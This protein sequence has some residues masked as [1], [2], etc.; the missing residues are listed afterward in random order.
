MIVMNPHLHAGECNCPCHASPPGT[1]ERTLPPIPS[2]PCT[3]QPCPRCGLIVDDR[4]VITHAVTC[5]YVAAYRA[6]LNGGPP[7]RFPQWAGRPGDVPPL[8]PFYVPPSGVTAQ[9]R[10]DSAG[11]LPECPCDIC[12]SIRRR[13][14]GWW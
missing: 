8:V 1:C 10:A 12:R 9:D 13:Q 6:S 11:H 4:N 5:C 14:A 3:C 2:D 7:Y